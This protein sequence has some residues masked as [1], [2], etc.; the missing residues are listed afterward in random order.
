MKALRFR[1][2]WDVARPA[3]QAD[4]A[5]RTV[6]HLVQQV[7]PEGQ[8]S[9]AT[10]MARELQPAPQQR[11]SSPP[12]AAVKRTVDE[13]SPE[14]EGAVEEPSALDQVLEDVGIEA[15]PRALPPRRLTYALA[16]GQVG[17][18]PSFLPKGG[19]ANRPEKQRRARGT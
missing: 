14:K 10:A 7:P 2:M 9:E 13:R 1:R 16:A 6:A 11:P 12:R 15:Q 8:Q 18:G 17:G 19:G 4:I 5:R 3:L